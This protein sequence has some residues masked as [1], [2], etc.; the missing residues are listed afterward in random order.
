MRTLYIECAMG[1]AGDMLMGALYE[2]LEDKAAFLEK[3]NGLEL[4]GVHIHA[5]SAKKS[6]IA[7]THMSVHVHGHEEHSHDHHEGEHHHHHHHEHSHHHYSLKDVLDIINGLDIPA[8]VKEKAFGVYDAIAKAESRA[9]GT[10]VEMVHFHEVGS[11]D[12]IADV[13]GCCYAL[14]L[15]APERVVVSPVRT[16][17]GQVHCAHG[18]MPVPAPATAYLL[19]GVPSYAGDIKG[20]MCTPTGAA[21]VKTFADSFGEKP[22]M[23][24]QAVGHGMGTKDFGAANCV[25]AFL[26]EMQEENTDCV[27]EL[28]CN[29]DDMTAEALS[30]AM[31]RI[32]E[33]GA[34]DVSAVP[35]TMKKGR[36]GHILYVIAR[37][38]EAEAVARAVL[39]NTRTNG[40]R[41]H[42]CRRMKL[43]Y[44]FKK[45]S[46]PY[47]DVTIKYVS[48]YG[49]QRSKPEYEDVA[50]LA[51]EN[52]VPFHDVGESARKNS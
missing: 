51:K 9:H 47:G 37:P 1:V 12:A 46:T 26:G 3:M 20:E 49:V 16:G 48:G 24:T 8:E 21:L 52:N 22:L 43:G 36:A 35:A 41:M 13:V 11:M 32:M 15:I 27:T 19:E 28:A 17:Y 4:H 45:V 14:H 42:D 39:L 40:V 25:R 34:L 10:E 31:E 30:Y 6:G 44:E 7:G 5:M 2:L 38:D 29:I 50:R 33:A 18:I 23:V